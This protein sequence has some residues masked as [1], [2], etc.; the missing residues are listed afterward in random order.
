MYR[1]KYTVTFIDSKWSVIKKNVNLIS[2]PRF[3]EYIFFD[4]LYYEVMQV[5]HEVF[6]KPKFFGPKSR[7]LIVI[8]PFSHQKI[9]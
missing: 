4:G 7:I 5:V 9:D 2:V 1:R 3:G 6:E 8:K